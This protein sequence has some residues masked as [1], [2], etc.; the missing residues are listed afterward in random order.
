MKVRALPMCSKPV[1]DGA[2]RTR[3]IKFKNT[4]SR[5]QNSADGGRQ[6]ADGRKQRP[7]TR[8]QKLVT[9]N[10]KPVIWRL[11]SLGRLVR[12]DAAGRRCRRAGCGR[13]G[14]RPS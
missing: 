11:R 12:L 5:S 6:A 3:G 4:E 9:R 13:L 14:I 8:N 2:K 10:Q 7:A 1:G